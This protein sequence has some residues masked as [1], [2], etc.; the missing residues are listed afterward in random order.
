MFPRMTQAL[1][2]THGLMEYESIIFKKAE[3]DINTLKLTNGLGV[4][5]AYLATAVG[6]A[7]CIAVPHLPPI[8]KVLNSLGRILDVALGNLLVQSEAIYRPDA[9]L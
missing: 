6:T 7:D 8:V 1:P 5:K 2:H 3:Q 4:P 9:L